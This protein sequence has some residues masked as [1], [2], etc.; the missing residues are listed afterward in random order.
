VPGN[1]GYYVHLSEILPSG[2]TKDLYDKEF[3]KVE[4]LKL[5]FPKD[6]SYVYWVSTGTEVPKCEFAG[7]VDL[8]SPSEQEV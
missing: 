7:H 5:S 8:L 4:K 6:K 2:D 3:H 1:T